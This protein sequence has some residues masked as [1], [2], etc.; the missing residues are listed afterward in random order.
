ML[1]LPFENAIECHYLYFFQV[2]L[3]PGL[4]NFLT[5]MA[6]HSSAEYLKRTP[7]RS[8]EFSLYIFLSPSVLCPAD[9]SHHASLDYALSI[10]LRESTGF[11]WMPSLCN[12]TWKLSRQWV[13]TIIGFTSL[14][15]HFSGSLYFV[16][17]C[18]VSWKPLFHIFSL[19]F[20]LVVSCVRVNLVPVTSSWTEAEVHIFQIL[21]NPNICFIFHLR[22]LPIKPVFYWMAKLR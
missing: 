19:P 8:A 13:G 4:G 14:V 17:W 7:W 20:F 22:R 5:H 11:A 18:S 21:F 9:S 3:F 16:P 6:N 10:Q 1:F 12:M 2:V 15:S